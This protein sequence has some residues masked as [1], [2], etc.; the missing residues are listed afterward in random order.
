MGFSI[1]DIPVIGDIHK[2]IWGD[3]DAIKSAYDKQIAASQQQ[4][5]QMKDF[6]MG[7]KGAAQAF[8]APMQHIFN[9][10][11]G[12]EGI[13]GPMTPQVPG[14]RLEGMYQTQAAPPQASAGAAP[15]MG[16]GGRAPDPGK[17]MR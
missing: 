6:L 16:R 13:D 3:P 11:Y 7:Q 15:P 5:D 10:M 2:G 17:G 1:G 12:T 14:G 4:S 9:K 8:Y